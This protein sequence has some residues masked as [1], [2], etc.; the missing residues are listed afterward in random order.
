MVIRS[1]YCPNGHKW[2]EA[3]DCKQC[4]VC[5]GQADTIGDGNS[6]LEST[7]AGAVRPGGGSSADS[8]RSQFGRYLVIEEL[9]RGGMGIVY[10]V[11]DPV[12]KRQV[13]LKTLPNTDPTLLSRFKREFRV[14]AEVDHPNVAKH[15]ELTSDGETWFFTMEIIEGVD[16]LDYVQYGFSPPPAEIEELADE[17]DTA[18]TVELSP[19]KLS[20]EMKQRLRDGFAQLAGAVA[21]LHASGVI[22]R[23][24]KPS[25][26]IVTL[27]SRVVLLDFGLVAETDPSGIHLSLHQ[28]LMG[29]VAYMS[30]EQAACDPVSAAS[31]WYSVGVMLYQS[32]TGRLPFKGKSLDILF[33]KQHRDAKPPRKITPFVSQE[34]N[35][36]CMGLLCRD[37][38]GRPAAEGIL[39]R[40]GGLARQSVP[41]KTA[42]PHTL[43][44]RE[45]Q[46]QSLHVTWEA[47][48]GGEAKCVFVEGGSGSGK[49]A[50]LEA[51]IEQATRGGAL[52]LRGRCYEMESVPFKAIDSLID[53]LV[54]HLTHFSEADA[55]ALVPRDIHAL[56]R[57][58]P[59][60]GR[61][62]AMASLP[63]RQIDTSDPQ[64]L[65]RRAIGALRE[66]LGRMGDRYP[67]VVYIDDLQ[68]GDEDSAAMLSNLLQPPDP[69]ILL[70]LGNYR[71]E[72]VETSEFLQSFRQIQH[73]REA[74]LDSLQ[75]EVE[76]LEH[77]DSI[78]LALA[79]LQRDDPE[80]RRDAE[81]VAREAAGNPFFVSEL[82]KHLQLEGGHFTKSDEPLDLRDMIWSR[83][84]RLPD[85]SQRLLAVV[86]LWGQPLPLDQ[87]MNIAE[88]GQLAVGPLRVGHLIRTA[89][90]SRI[91]TYHDRVRE[92]VSQLLSPATKQHYHLRI[93]EQC[94]QQSKL[95]AA[96]IMD[97]LDS[98]FA[99]RS[100]QIDAHI[101]VSSGWYD[102]AFHFD[103]A[104]RSDL[105]FPYASAAAE[106]SRTQFSLELAEHQFRIAERGVAGHGE[107]VKYRVAEGL[108]EVLMLRGRY[109]DAAIRFTT[110]MALTTDALM[111]AQLESKLGELAHKQGDMKT[112]IN[113]IEGALR[114]LGYRVP[115]W[116]GGF[117]LRL[118]REAVVQLFHT[119]LPRFFVGR[120]RL[121][122]VDKELLTIRLHNRLAYAYWFGSG[123]FQ[124]LW[125]H[126][127]GMNLAECYPPTPELGQAYSI[128]APVMSLV[129]YFSRGEAYAH[130]SLAVYKSLGD[131]WGQGQ[132]LHFYGV[133]LYAAS[134]YEECIEKC[135]EAM[136][137]LERT[138]DL[139]EL[140]IAR[141]H[142]ANCLYRLGDLPGSVAE[143]QRVYQS[144]V[145]LGDIQETGMCMDVW[146]LASGGQISPDILQTQLQLPREDVQV[147]AQVMFAEGVRLFMMDH[148]E[149]AAVV[150]DNGYQVA[151]EKGLKSAW[152]YPLRCWLASALRRRAE[153]TS[154][155][156]AGLRSALLKRASKVAR[157]AVKVARRFQNDL[158]HALREVGVISALQGSERRARSYLEESLEVA[159]RQGARFE[160]AQTLLA[161]GRVG[162]TLDWPGAAEEVAAAE[163]VLIELGADFVLQDQATPE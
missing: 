144:G 119:L 149:E 77:D 147:R 124:C 37:P 62:D 86:A 98:Y 146:A 106:K 13:A 107:L 67:L 100:A 85:E 137:L 105:A 61:V 115:R 116:F 145:E 163:Q 122:D 123:K 155:L 87:A 159:Q 65:N 99:D 93:A 127:R 46:L 41:T 139:W 23:D 79:L 59:V 103:A 102:V 83:V 22:H 28:Q 117:L 114:R 120:K 47:V 16:L 66:L 128:H 60:I 45:S 1:F 21:A 76:P 15:F 31:D 80:A 150:F 5:G 94:A 84:E 51:F 81:S 32:L 95:G 52:A 89:S 34:W 57:L 90:S 43:V 130:K 17:K 29:T 8:N 154:E 104:G 126:L 97:R 133:V 101:E 26:V 92:S 11:F 78:K 153:K 96:E 138:G 151:A 18:V 162:Q 72:D 88:V 143:A 148:L 4:P 132:S 14:M 40:L 33:K 71:S 110:A 42:Q 58:F 112:A 49:S 44:G 75:I 30:P 63:R 125:T 27:D 113:A 160:H 152:T 64:E 56:A 24:I 135:H 157:Q 10:R 158:P 2:Q 74:P 161:S 156:E 20:A 141:Y 55:A 36:L 6:H 109:P 108:G 68:W 53:S 35:D 9:G 121:Q 111:E 70:F 25:N 3:D 39:Q 82:V 69:P 131:L 136:R 38:Q 19:W 134:K 50:L 142:V 118:G 140:S 12:H 48:Q 54:E 73:Q 7:G 129:G 91:E